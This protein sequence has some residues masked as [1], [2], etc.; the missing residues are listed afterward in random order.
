M[1]RIIILALIIVL[2]TVACAPRYKESIKASGVYHQVQKGETLWR[3]AYTY[4]INIQELAEINNITDPTLVEVGDVIFIPDAREIREVVPPPPAATPPKEVVKPVVKE[5][6]KTVAKKA[7]V[8]KEEIKFERSR[9]IW[10]VNGAVSSKFGI[11]PN[12]MRSNGIKIDARE[13]TPVRAAASGRVSYSSHLKYYGET[14]IIKHNNNY[15]TVYA[16]LKGRRVNVGDRVT[17]GEEI[18]YLGNH[19]KRSGSCLYFE[20]RQLNKPKNPLFYLPKTKKSN[21]VENTSHV[22]K[23]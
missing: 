5:A 13:G 16:Y 2:S 4:N 10:P 14:I 19:G 12:E 3:I 15:T 7:E 22:K 21:P 23:K 9:F 8:K 11:Q 17:K 6:D 18:A 20:I 1:K